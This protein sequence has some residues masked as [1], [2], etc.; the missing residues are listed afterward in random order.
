MSKY[1]WYIYI[2][3]SETCIDHL[4]IDRCMRLY[5]HIHKF[6]FYISTSN[7]ITYILSFGMKVCMC[8]LKSRDKT[9][10][11]LQF[12]EF[13]KSTHLH[14]TIN[15]TS[16]DFLLYSNKKVIF[17][18]FHWASFCKFSFLAY[19]LSWR[20]TFKPCMFFF[21][22]FTWSIYFFWCQL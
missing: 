15:F 12:T 14:L 2:P 22:V 10:G 5:I 7:K 19:E 13:L 6:P 4:L 11:C 20:I 3:Y 8:F 1:C 16:A 17:Y 21:K 9:F 18:Y